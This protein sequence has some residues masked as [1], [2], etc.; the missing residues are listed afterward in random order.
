[1]G[2]G[3]HLILPCSSFEEY[4]AYSHNY[5]WVVLP[6]PAFAILGWHYKMVLDKDL[7]SL[8]CSSFEE[9]LVR[10]Q[11]YSGVVLLWL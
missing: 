11:Y 8:A 4:C 6:S 2:F 5:S 9:L 3:K 10:S 7:I 1:M